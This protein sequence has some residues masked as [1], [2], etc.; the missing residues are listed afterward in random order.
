MWE[1][2]NR[3]LNCMGTI[4]AGAETCPLCGKNGRSLSGEPGQLP[5][6]TILAGKY[7]VGRSLGRGSFGITYLGWD[8]QRE[9]RLAIK[10][11]FPRGFAR[12]EEGTQVFAEEKAPADVFSA[13]V[14]RFIREGEDVKKL[15]GDPGIVRVEDIFRENGTA[16]IAME[17]L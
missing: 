2:E 9:T 16:Y 10:E 11:Y 7:L 8:L 14:E 3:C 15:A 13:G 17:Y 4:P 5:P 6:G 12:R 1:I